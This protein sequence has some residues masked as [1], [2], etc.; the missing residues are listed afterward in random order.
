MSGSGMFGTQLTGDQIRAD[1]DKGGKAEVV[2]RRFADIPEP[3]T[4]DRCAKCGGPANFK[5]NHLVKE[6][7]RTGKGIVSRTYPTCES[8]AAFLVDQVQKFFDR[9]R[10]AAS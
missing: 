1:R 7:R 9:P 8:C 5:T 2:V 10:S 4:T 3:T 6:N